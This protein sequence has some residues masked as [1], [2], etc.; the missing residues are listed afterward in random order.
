MEVG[1][2]N[3]PVV[4]QVLPEMN[5]GG[6]EMGTV[7]IA[8][9]MVEQGIENYVASAGGR[10]VYDLQK[11][12]VKHFELPLKTKNIFKMWCN[13]KKLAKIIKENNINIVHARS[14]APAW[15]AYWAAKKT[16]AVFLTTYHGTYGLGP[17]KIKKFYNRVMTYGKLVIAISE[18]IKKHI[19]KEYNVPEDKIRLVHRCVNL[20]N[21]SPE[22]VSKERIIKTVQD[23][24]IPES[25][26]V[27]SLIGRVTPWKGQALLIEALTKVKN[28]DFYC[29]IV[30]SDQGRTAF[31]NKLKEMVKKYGLESKVQFIDHSF[32]IPALLMVSNVVLSTAVEPE[33]F[34]RAAIEGQA[35][36]KI[37]IASNIGGSLE[38]TIDGVTGKLFESGNVDELAA[39]IDWALSLSDEEKNKIGAAAI[40][41]VKE[42]FTKEIMCAKTIAVYNELMS[43]K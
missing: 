1:K 29:L 12:K 31:S 20:D 15:S 19:I 6:V 14:R 24:N 3:K 38:N 17:L 4:L 11:L 26:P 40:K 22:K 41:N 36:G 42:H 28:S 23:F 9:G 30:G 35:M 18:H 33:A 16:G 8:S 5:H 13:A 34:G 32:D 39:S 7:E 37:V 2:S 43:M 10:M 25:S 21:F 27:I